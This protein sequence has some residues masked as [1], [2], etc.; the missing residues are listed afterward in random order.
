MLSLKRGSGATLEAAR[1]RASVMAIDRAPTGPTVLVPMVQARIKCPVARARIARDLAS[2]VAFGALRGVAL[3]VHPA[4]IRLSAHGVVCYVGDAPDARFDPPETVC[5]AAWSIGCVLHKLITGSAPV[6]S[7]D[8]DR[9]RAI[10]RCLGAPTLAE[11]HALCL[12]HHESARRRARVRGA[13][14]AE[15]ILL[16]STL[17]WDPARRLVC[18]TRGL[19]SALGRVSEDGTPR[20]CARRRWNRLLRRVCYCDRDGDDPCA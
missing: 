2:A 12:P 10:V 8:A 17:A 9:M 7:N 1:I 3:V 13:S 5:S 18:T 19:E 16:R 11:S 14:F 4:L 15:R 20:T 6:A